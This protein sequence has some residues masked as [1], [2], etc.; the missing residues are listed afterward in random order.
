MARW[1]LSWAWTSRCL[2]ELMLRLERRSRERKALR[3]RGLFVEVSE[4]KKGRAVLG[5][6]PRFLKAQRG[7]MERKRRREGGPSRE[8][9][10]P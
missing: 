4:R 6:K 7:D 2:R 10:R 3:A 8:D 5:G 9:R 1:H